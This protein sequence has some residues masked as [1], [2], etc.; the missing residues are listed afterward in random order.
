MHCTYV[1][2]GRAVCVRIVYSGAMAVFRV[3]KNNVDH[4]HKVHR[5]RRPPVGEDDTA[6]H[7]GTLSEYELDYRGERERRGKSAG[8]GESEITAECTRRCSV[9]SVEKRRAI[10]FPTLPAKSL[11]RV[12]KRVRRRP[13]ENSLRRSRNQMSPPLPVPALTFPA[14]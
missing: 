14:L 8:G 11:S 3:R 12:T 4:F 1:C 5:S 10:V 6:C 2:R 9:R 13:E 7:H